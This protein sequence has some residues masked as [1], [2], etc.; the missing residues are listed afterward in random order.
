MQRTEQSQ[1]SLKRKNKARGIT[2]PDFKIC[3]EAMV[4]K[5]V[6]YLHKDRHTNQWYTIES[7]EIN[8]CIYGQLTF[9]KSAN[10]AQ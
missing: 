8:P 10:S 7:L 6:W 3:Y 4:I 9:Y 5:T 2:V 1:I